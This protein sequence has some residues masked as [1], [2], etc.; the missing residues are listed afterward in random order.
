MR[1]ETSNRVETRY[2]RTD[3]AHELGGSS[4]KERRAKLVD[5]VRENS[6]EVDRQRG[7]TRSIGAE[8]LK[9]KRIRAETRE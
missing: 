5:K 7:K 1:K 6:S 2:L 4:K 8:R 3:A 9:G